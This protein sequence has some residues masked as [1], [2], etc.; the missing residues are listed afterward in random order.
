MKARYDHRETPEYFFRIFLQI[1]LKKG[2]FIWDN[3]WQGH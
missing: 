2:I 1:S 3:N